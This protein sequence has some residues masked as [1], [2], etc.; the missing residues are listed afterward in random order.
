MEKVEVYVDGSYNKALPDIVHG[1]AII[2]V[3][4]EATFCRRY[5]TKSKPFVQSWNVGG[6]LIAAMLGITDAL[7]KYGTS[8]PIV[9]KYDYEGIERWIQG[10]TKWRAKTPC[11]MFYVSTMQKIKGK[12]P[13]LNL[14]FEKVKAHSGEKWNELVDRVANGQFTAEL[15][16]VRAEDIVIG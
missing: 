5:A 16:G 9:L 11:A 4:G 15:E 6:E 10:R 1:G 12:N 8:L 3:D 7:A 13:S 14:S 2:V